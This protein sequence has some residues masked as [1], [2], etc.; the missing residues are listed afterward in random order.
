MMWR[1]PIKIT[2]PFGSKTVGTMLLMASFVALC[3]L[4]LFLGLSAFAAAL[5]LYWGE[6]RVTLLMFVSIAVPVFVFILFD[7]VFE[8]RFPRGILTNLWYG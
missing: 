2:E 1:D 5:A 4:D 3:Q 7:Q 6:R 8:I